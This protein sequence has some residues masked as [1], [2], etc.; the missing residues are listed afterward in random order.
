MLATQCLTL[1]IFL[2]SYMYHYI[3]SSIED[4]GIIIVPAIAR[5]P[6]RVTYDF[7]LIPWERWTFPG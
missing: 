2:G 6:A 7:P 4:A 1:K 5:G 3:E